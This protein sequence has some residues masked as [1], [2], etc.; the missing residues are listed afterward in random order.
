MVIVEVQEPGGSEWRVVFADG[1]LDAKR[2]AGVQRELRKEGLASPQKS[3]VE[4]L[5]EN[6]DTRLPKQV[7]CH[8]YFDT[9]MLEGTSLRPRAGIAAYRGIHNAFRTSRKDSDYGILCLVEERPTKEVSEY[10]QYLEKLGLAIRERQSYSDIA[11]YEASCNRLGE[12]IIEPY[13]APCVFAEQIIRR[14]CF[15]HVKA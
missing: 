8:G 6:V 14:A 11:G 5:V 1:Y 15:R 3:L 2:I 7:E 13:V 12:K 10:A 4:D 9:F